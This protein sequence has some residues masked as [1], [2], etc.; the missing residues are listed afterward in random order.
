MAF[1][2]LIPTSKNLPNLPPP[3][4]SFHN[5]IS[6]TSFPQQPFHKRIVGCGMGDVNFPKFL[7]VTLL[8]QIFSRNY[9]DRHIFA[10]FSMTVDLLFG[11]DVIDLCGSFIA[12]A[13]FIMDLY[14]TG[15]SSSVDSI[16]SVYSLQ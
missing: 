6:T 8:P 9:Y 13:T 7:H 12:L 16:S 15:R 14:W 4:L 3:Q 2:I 1:V 10:D 5:I 11:A